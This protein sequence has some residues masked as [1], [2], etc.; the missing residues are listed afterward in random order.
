MIGILTSSRDPAGVNIRNYLLKEYFTEKKGIFDDTPVFT[1][2]E[3]VLVETKSSLLE[4]DPKLDDHFDVDFWLFGS[5][6]ASSENVPALT[7]HSPGNWND[8]K[9]GGKPNELAF[10][11]ACAIKNC[12]LNLHNSPN[13]AKYEVCLEVTHHGP[14]SLKKPVIFV[15]IGSSKEYWED[16]V[17]AAVVSEAIL[18]A[19][20]RQDWDVCV[21]FG[22]THYAPGFTKLLLNTNYATGHIGPKYVTFSHEN[23]KMAI[24]KTKMAKSVVLDWKGL[25]YEQKSLIRQF[26]SEQSLPVYKLGELK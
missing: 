5:K 15:E 6:H 16:G 1:F 24:E 26:L 13:R 9:Y 3:F 21:G 10:S 17:A 20:E 18:K 11:D 22:G 23:I 7:V 19:N 2:N 12:L 4:V 25:N 14:T 8:A